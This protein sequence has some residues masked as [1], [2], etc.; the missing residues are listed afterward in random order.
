MSQS[1][2]SAAKKK[3]F[4]SAVVAWVVLPEAGVSV[5]GQL[6]KNMRGC[7]HAYV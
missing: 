1:I 3:L 5:A 4:P 7:F 2:C 6:S